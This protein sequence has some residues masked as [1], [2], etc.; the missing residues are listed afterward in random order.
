M[1]V[2]DTI[3]SVLLLL[4]HRMNNRIEVEKHYGPERMLYCYAGR[5]ESGRDEPNFERQ[6]MRSAVKERS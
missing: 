3:D 6:P 5:L 4:K 2:A 1:D